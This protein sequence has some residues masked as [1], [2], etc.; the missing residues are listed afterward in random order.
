MMNIL[1][2]WFPAS[3]GPSV[4][5]AI[6]KR[7]ETWLAKKPVVRDPYIFNRK[8]AA[9]GSL[10]REVTCK[11]QKWNINADGFHPILVANARVDWLALKDDDITKKFPIL[12][13]GILQDVFSQRASSAWQGAQPQKL[14]VSML[15]PG[16][17]TASERRDLLQSR[18]QFWPTLT[19]RHASLVPVC[20]EALQRE[21][22]QMQAKHL[23][24][25]LDI[26]WVDLEEKLQVLAPT[27]LTRDDIWRHLFLT[28]QRKNPFVEGC[29]TGEDLEDVKLI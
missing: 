25:N 29:Y 15:L 7:N 12:L 2:I 26:R 21:R 3:W 19:T 10:S 1:Y 17:S 13:E 18:R 14:T 16:T 4:V 9:M 22:R 28:K 8:E 23:W 5:E 24:Y 27:G 6:Q 11:I 20:T